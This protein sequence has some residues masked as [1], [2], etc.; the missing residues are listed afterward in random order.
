MQLSK[1]I[2]IFIQVM[3]QILRDQCWSWEKIFEKYL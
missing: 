1:W 3:I 2:I